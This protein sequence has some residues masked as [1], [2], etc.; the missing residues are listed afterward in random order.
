M[1][2]LLNVIVL[3]DWDLT[4]LPIL[5]GPAEIVDLAGPVAR[6]WPENGRREVVGRR[7]ASLSPASEP[8]MIEL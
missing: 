2:F 3:A 7:T 8:T 6:E 1:T 5:V 4:T